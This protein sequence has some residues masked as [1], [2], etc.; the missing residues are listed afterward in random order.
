VVSARTD[1]LAALETIRER[2]DLNAVVPNATNPDTPLEPTHFARGGLN[3]V[4]TIEGGA[5]GFDA[6]RQVAIDAIRELV[7]ATNAS[8]GTASWTSNESSPAPESHTH[9][10]SNDT[11]GSTPTYGVAS[12]DGLPTSNSEEDQDAEA[13]DTGSEQP[14]YGT[15]SADGLPLSNPEEDQDEEAPLLLPEPGAMPTIVVA[16]LSLG[17]VSR[18]QRARTSRS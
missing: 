11:R 10:R 18:A 14:T 8:S 9:L 15:A 2:V 13:S 3:L 4:R 16:L 6:L 5:L 17:A 12:A 1:A 7:V